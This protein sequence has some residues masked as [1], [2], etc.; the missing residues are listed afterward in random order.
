MIRAA[1]FEARAASDV[2]SVC[3]LSDLSHEDGKSRFLTRASRV[4]GMTNFYR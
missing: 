1:N 3:D 4:F 2:E